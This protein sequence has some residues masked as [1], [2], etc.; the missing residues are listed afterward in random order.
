VTRTDGFGLFANS[1]GDKQRDSL[2]PTG[3][4]S[5]EAFSDQRFP[6]L[7]FR[8]AGTV[9]DEEAAGSNPASPTTL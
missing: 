2:S 4:Q 3:E 5:A 9:R 7:I 8:V 1:Q 6:F